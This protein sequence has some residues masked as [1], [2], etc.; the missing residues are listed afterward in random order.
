MHIT[1]IHERKI[2]APDR[3]IGALI[4]TI[5]S[6]DDRIWP[7]ENW[8]RIKFDRPLEI[9]ALGGHGPVRYTVES[10][11]PGKSI[12]FAFTKRFDGYHEI[13]LEKIDETTSLMRHTIK[14]KTTGLATMTWLLAIRPLHNAL[15]EDLFDKVEMQLSCN[16][17]PR[18]WGVWVKLLRNLRGIDTP[19]RR[20]NLKRRKHNFSSIK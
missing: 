1:N 3:N 6:T 14:A 15:I 5:S 13:T 9:G 20:R 16:P 17:R 7:H 8:P 10:Y 19:N 12:R 4:D 11:S 2:S 18:S